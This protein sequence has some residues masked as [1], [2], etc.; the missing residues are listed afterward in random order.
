M[1]ALSANTQSLIAGALFDFVGH[2]SSIPKTAQLGS[3]ERSPYAY[4][5]S[6]ELKKWAYKRGL[7]LKS[8]NSDWNKHS[9]EIT[10]E[11]L[12]NEGADNLHRVT[13]ALQAFAQDFTTKDTENPENFLRK[14]ATRHKLELSNPQHRWF[15][16][17]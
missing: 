2:L 1:M 6:E 3:S 16:L 11:M 8:A 17:L 12:A 7:D 10:L 13:G 5:P 15:V 14:W 4:A 9:G